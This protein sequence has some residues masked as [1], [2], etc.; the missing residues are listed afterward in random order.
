MWWMYFDGEDERAER[1]LAAATGERGT[2]LSLYAFG[3]DF[4]PL[5]E[6][7]VVFAAGVKLAM[8]NHGVPASAPTAWFIAAGVATYALGLC[9]FRKTLRTGPVAYRLGFAVLALLTAFLG[10]AVSPEAQ[11]AAVLALALG[12]LVLER[13]AAP[14]PAA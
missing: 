3:F 10:M 14:V 5:L 4:L 6:G 11:L 12:M 2:W 8:A 1:A 13:R 9:A 7:I